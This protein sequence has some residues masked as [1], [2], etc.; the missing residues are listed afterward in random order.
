MK[1]TITLLESLF[2][3]SALVACNA[4]PT[5]Y[6]FKVKDVEGAFDFHTELQNKYINSEDYS[7]TNGIA[8][9]SSS[10]EQPLPIAINWEGSKS[11]TNKKPKYFIV[12]IYEGNSETPWY[13][14]SS[15]TNFDQ[16][17]FYNFKLDTEY[18]YQVT[19]Y[20][21]DALQFKSEKK[22]FRTTDKG[23]RNLY[24]NNV[25]N[26]RDL[27]G[28]GIKQ[29]LIYRSGRFNEDE[30]LDGASLLDEQ[31]KDVLLNTLKIKT[32]VDLR[33]PGENGN[34]KASP[35]GEMVSYNHLPMYYGGENVLTYVGER[36]SFLYDNPA[37]I[38]EFFELLSD[39]NNYP[40]DFHCAIGKDRTG[41]MAY[42]IE[43]LCGIEEEYLY[44]DYLFS[45]FAKISGICK[46]E[47]I[48]DRYGATLK[49]YEGETLQEKTYNYL[50]KVIGVSTE[51]LDAIKDILIDK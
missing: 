23:P 19:A 17:E 36:N 48:D 42:L 34:I 16:D 5:S 14:R 44:R 26:I 11:N 4:N 37:R 50:N 51:K 39:R 33:R 27:G 47:D 12:D 22:A 15:I 3:L 10:K 13:T 6:E 7:S 2:L 29:G 20:Y 49:A 8:A 35:L 28:H 46:T 43:A 21:S 45:N 38:K 41:C 40:I 18:Q 24:V 1:K 9:G 30:D 25:M 31:S 32:E